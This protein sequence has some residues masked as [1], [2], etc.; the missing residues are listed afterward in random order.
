MSQEHNGHILLCEGLRKSYGDRLAVDGVGFYIARG[1][2]YGLLGPNGAAVL[3][4]FAIG[5]LALATWRL[6]G[7]IVAA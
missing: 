2:T 4:A 6:H 1:E 3:A 5:L 7:G